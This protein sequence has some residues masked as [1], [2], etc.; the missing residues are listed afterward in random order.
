MSATVQDNGAAPPAPPPQQPN[1]PI[2]IASIYV[3]DL[4]ATINEPQ[5]VELFKTFGTILNVRV[6]RD[7]ITQRSLGYGYVNF[8]NHND[9]EKAIEAMNFKRVGDKCMRLMWQQRDPALRYSG[10]GNI[11]VKN[12]ETEVD[13]KSLHDLFTKFGAILSCKVMEDEEGK[14]RGYGFVH[15]KEETSA[16][17]AIVKMNGSTDHANEEK[18]ALYVA[19]FIRRNA[20]LAALVANFTNVYIKQVLPSVNKDVIEK[21][22]AKFGGITSAA[23]CKDKSGRVFAFCNFEKHDDAVKAIEAMHDHHIDGIT[24]PGE[25]LYVQRAQPRSERLIALRQ[26]YMQHQSLGN[27]L[28]VRNFDPEFTDAD[29]LELFKEYGN[30]KSCRVMVSENG[31]SRGF[32]F[33]SFTD[34]DEANAALREMNGRMLNGKPLIVNIAQRRDQRYTMLRMQFQQRLQMMMRQMH[35]QMPFVGGQQGRPMRGRGGRQQHGG[36]AQGHPMPMPSPQQQ[37]QQQPQVAPQ[38]QQIGFATP[39]KSGF[40][41]ATPKHSPGQAP[42]TP[43]LPPITPQELESMSP[44]EQRAALGDRLFLKVYDIAPELAPKITGMFL[45]MKFKDAY[46]LLNDQKRLEDRVTEALCVL[47]AHQTA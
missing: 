21:F 32:G 43:P 24:A 9:A 45:E 39:A 25:K 27:N 12:L 37:Q 22:F 17:D 18:K 10:N 13:S 2:Q 14:S 3:G 31:A 33:V 46:E 4:D 20:R 6:C 30:V 7:I 11:F 15:F 38:Q 29:L 26:K 47:Q 35:Q 16:T 41:S 1:K 34:A 44:Q 23:A 28:Y 36:R 8:D 40:V 19:N 42:E 5:L